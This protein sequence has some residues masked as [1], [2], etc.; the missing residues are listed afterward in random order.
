MKNE[1]IKETNDINSNKEK[2]VEIK[3]LSHAKK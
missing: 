1:E 2:E 3:Q